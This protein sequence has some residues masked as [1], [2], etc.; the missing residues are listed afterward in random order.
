MDVPEMYA[1]EVRRQ[2]DA[3]W[4]MVDEASALAK[5]DDLPGLR[6]HA[7]EIRRGLEAGNSID[8]TG[9]HLD[10]N[11]G[12]IHASLDD[13][14][15]AA[16]P[17]QNP[18]DPADVLETPWPTASR[19]AQLASIVDHVGWPKPPLEP[20]ADRAIA[21]N[22][23]HL[24][25]LL[26]L[27]PLGRASRATVV[28][29][30]DALHEVGAL[31]VEIIE[32]AFTDDEYLGNAI[33]GRSPADGAE[34]SMPHACTPA[35]RDYFDEVAW[36]LTSPPEPEWTA[37]PEVL[38]PRGLRFVLR[39]MER[40]TD[41]RM[42]VRLG[43]AELTDGERTALVEHLRDRPAE[44]RRY[45]FDLRL[46]AG[47]AGVLLPLL[48]LPGAEPLLRLV[49]ATS[50]TEA[51]RQDRSAILAAVRQAGVDG[52]RRLLRICP[53][54]IVSAALGWNRAAVSK[55][56]K[57][58]ALAGIAAF[59]LLPL[60]DG[61]TVLDRYMALRE[62][63]KRGPKLG[64][65]RRH[66]H[67]AAVAVALDHL[68][69][70]TAFPDAE[71]LEWDCEARIATE[72]P[73]EWHIGDYTVAL[74]LSDAEPLITIS[75]AGRQLTSVPAAV[76]ADPRYPEVREHQERLRDQARRIRTG[77]I[78]RLVATGGT[79]APDELARLRSLPAG[80]VMLPALIWQD[81]VGTIGLLDQVDLDGPVTVVHPSLLYERDLLAHWQAEVVRQRI[82]QPV[83][84]AFRELYLL[85]P[86]ERDAVDVSRRFAGHTVDGKVSGQL[87][88]GRGWST[89]GQYQQHQATR[90][91]TTEITAALVCDLP[92]Y[93]G[94]GEV[95]VGELRFLA[96]GSVVPLADVPPVAFSEVMRDLDLVVSVAGIDPAGYASP[97]H[98]ASRAHLL[99]SLVD[100][101]GLARV[102]VDGTS[103]VVRGSRATY[104]VHLN[105][106]S[107][108]VEP[109]GYLCVVPASFGGTAHPSL[110][111]PFAD[112]DRIT[113]VI[114]S[115]VLLLNEDEKIT[116]PTI[117]A[118]L[119]PRA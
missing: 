62:V 117:L 7:K 79:L 39:A 65:N 20:L 55:R 57:H 73:G 74:R 33:V 25:R 47:D 99:A 15:D 111:L 86:A 40:P 97:L 118:Q 56:V 37:L 50:T 102:T 18:D 85:T 108:H 3:L 58:N 67:A 19:T 78:E 11:V 61:E 81:Q 88:S 101:L 106:G 38:V 52:A 35:V 46:P 17:V 60:A 26:V 70:V 51:V 72:T 96:A 83:K 59:G 49:Q 23:V 34:R 90:P 45:A 28:R 103:A 116:D 68:A 31:D 76:R 91:V 100:D 42:A 63:A 44:E 43:A 29:V 89:H 54:E 87:L 21:A 69:Q 41:R 71:R 8:R 12:D 110:F 14:Y 1:D 113:S 80:A 115:K 13:I 10:S 36:R 95:V 24:L 53:S 84:Q 112:E 16:F 77:L 66:S 2:R 6:A 75:K 82:R 4:G 30:L 64:P 27:T 94:G 22:D 5:A 109:G 98:G 107:I 9:G 104:R 32:Q 48:G 114:L 105:S 93:F 92:G 119:G